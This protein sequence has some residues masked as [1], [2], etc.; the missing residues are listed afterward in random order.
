[1]YTGMAAFDLAGTIIWNVDLVAASIIFGGLFGAIALPVGL[2][3][4]TARWRAGGA[5]LLT[6]AICSHHFIGM[7][8][9]SI[10]PNPSIPI[11]SLSIP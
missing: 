2:H 7:S 6:L 1:H 3:G 9:A 4:T 10:I 8:A 5:L 11:S